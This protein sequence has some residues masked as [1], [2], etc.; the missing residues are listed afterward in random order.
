MVSIREA[1]E[2]DWPAVWAM[3][4]HVAAV[5]EAFAYDASTSESAARALWF[6]PP[7]SP[8]VAEDGSRVIG[9][10]Y[11]RPNQ[12]GRGSH[13]ANAG[14]MVADDARGRG[15]ASA[16]CAHSIATARRLGFTAMQ[17]NFVVATNIAAVRVWEKYGFTVVGRVPRAFRHA[18]LGLIDALIMH[19][20][21]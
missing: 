18:T 8:F 4:Q 2:A 1:T 15:I 6:E 12:P 5:G 19:R 9:T 11:L 16:R 3:F 17:F 7:S 10:Y 14:Y 21:V 13:I 20:D